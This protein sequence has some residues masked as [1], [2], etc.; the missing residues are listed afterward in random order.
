MDT[1]LSHSDNRKALVFIALLVAAGLVGIGLRIALWEG[2][3]APPQD[4]ST[5]LL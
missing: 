3:S 4:S 1:V 5:R 2:G